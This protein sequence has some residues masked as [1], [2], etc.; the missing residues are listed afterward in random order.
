MNRSLSISNLIED[1][2]KIQAKKNALETQFAIT[3]SRVAYIAE[4]PVATLA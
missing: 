4:I 2:G 1:A 3:I